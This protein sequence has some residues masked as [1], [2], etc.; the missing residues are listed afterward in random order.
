MSNII[1]K[2][3]EISLWEDVLVFKVSFYENEVVVDEKFYEG[4]LENFLNPNG[5]ETNIVQYF[6]EKKICT[7]GSDV[8]DSPIRTI[9]PKLIKNTNGTSTLTFSLYQKYSDE[10]GNFYDNP[11]IS[12]LV[13]ERKIKLRYGAIDAEDCEWYDFIVKNIEENSETNIFT[14][15]AKDLFINELSKSGFNLVFDQELENNQ[16]NIVELGNRILEGSDWQ[17]P[18]DFSILLQQTNEEPLYSIIT[19]REIQGINMTDT[20]DI[21]TIPENST[22]YG[23]YTPIASEN[24]F[25]Q[26]LYVE[27]GEYKFDENYVITNS[28]NYYIENIQYNNGYPDFVKQNFNDYAMTVS[29]EYRGARLVRKNLTKYDPVLDKYVNI[30]EDNGREVYGYSEFEYITPISVNNFVTNPNNF[31]SYTGWAEGG[32]QSQEQ[33]IYPELNLKTL[34]DIS[35]IDNYSDNVQFGSYLTVTFNEQNQYLFN[36][37]IKDFRS[38]INGFAE[39]E[40]YVFRVKYGEPNE[41]QDNIQNTNVKLFARIS[42]YNLQN[43]VYTFIKDYFNFTL[44]GADSANYLQSI[45]TS[46]YALSYSEMLNTSIGLFIYSDTLD[47]EIY[48]QDIQLFPYRL[49]SNNNICIPGQEIS[50]GIK[51]NYYY[52]YPSL[53][54]TSPEE[55]EYIIPSENIKTVFND[56]EGYQKVRSITES[57]SNRF[58]LIQVLCE[59]FECWPKF[60]VEHNQHTGE[61][62]LDENYR[63]L[64]WVTFQEFIASENQVGFKY[65][66]NLKSIVR[67]IESEDI[68]S[69]IV[70]KDNSNEFATDGFCSIARASENLTG[71]NFIYDFSYYINQNLLGFNEVNNDLYMDTN[72]YIG[73]YT[74]LR[75]Y[76]TERDQLINEQSELITSESKYNAAYQAYS[77][78]VSTAEEQKASKEVEIQSI[79]G[80]S[81]SEIM[82]ARSTDEDTRAFDW[83]NNS[84]VNK[85]CSSILRLNS[86]I[87]TQSVLRDQAEANLNRIINRQREIEERLSA[88]AD[89]KLRLEVQ[90]YKKY[91]RFIQE[92]PWISEDYIDDNLYYFDAQSTLHTSSQPKISYTINVLELSQKEE[93][94]NYVFALGDKTYIEDTEFFGWQMINGVQTPR[95]EEII[96]NEITYELD[97]PENNIITVQNYKTQFEDLFQRISATTQTVE[98]S[99][100]KYNK[101][102]QIV[103]EDGTINIATLQNSIINSA[104]I[105]QNAKD[106]S[107][108]W[109]ESGF[110]TVSPSAPNEIVRI[111]S[112][113]VFLSDDGGGTWNTG[114]TGK[115]IN[116][117]YITSGQLDTSVIRIMNGSFPSFR[118]DDNGLSAFEFEIDSNTGKAKNF[119]FSNFI[120]FDQYG[121]Y[122]IRGYANFDPNTPEDNKTGQEKIWNNADFALTWDGFLLKSNHGVHSGHISISSTNDFQVINSSGRDQIKI[123]LL[124]VVNDKAIYGLQIKDETG[125]IV[126][127]NASDGK[128]WIRNELKIGTEDTSTV[129]LG[130]LNLTKPGTN[131]HEVFHAGQDNDKQF[132]VYEDGTMKASGGEFTGTIH[133]TGGTIGNLSI[134]ELENFEASVYTVSIESDSGVFF[135]NG[136]GSKILTAYLYKG[137]EIYAD[138]G[139]FTYQW[140]VNGEPIAAAE[141]GQNKTLQVDAADLEDITQGVTYSCAI[142]FGATA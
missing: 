54:Y 26:F 67:T 25:V 44:D 68:V 107:V 14:Y 2:P 79:T 19:N 132:I 48:L 47:K 138:N 7:I 16:G 69:K 70:V 94:E 98:Y 50:S 102:S 38:E 33:T 13:N 58:N 29:S 21:I 134:S 20:S 120:R 10:L 27:S 127:E 114:V 57:E 122:G 123:G 113:G 49:D 35:R 97:S 128:V 51:E 140:Y 17:I 139:S 118:W 95:R 91:S 9:Q 103:N 60:I 125:Q 88:I 106:Q 12:L 52:Y 41:N 112:G 73:Y 46:N 15:T 116:A 59:T 82:N 84:E 43:G 1:K 5:Y 133:A 131:I 117:S 101:V 99:T 80:F 32:V 78:S 24:P 93:Y 96:I 86:I 71:E 62:L 92:G 63:Q 31:D 130:Y 11:F 4:S 141:G 104:L 136:S 42:E 129:G 119:N 56:Q 22:I 83:K 108:T 3:Y 34:P 135:K 39:G 109:D 36:S 124:S 137:G 142:S 37:G 87:N 64:K 45:S 28:P 72:G 61:I 40:S 53:S 115:G 23:F 90:F 121:V 110:Y 75:R 65:G 18:E 6:K 55:I 81:F 30:Y 77:L 66:I 8:M 105:L 85:L 111:V 74:R 126:L 89:D 76:N 100:G